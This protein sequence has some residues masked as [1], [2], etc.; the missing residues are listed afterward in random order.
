MFSRVFKNF[1]TIKYP[2]KNSDTRQM[3]SNMINCVEYLS[4]SKKTR[5]FD[6]MNNTMMIMDRLPDT[7]KLESLHDIHDLIL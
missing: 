7:L 1:F 5:V 3:Y 2:R 4:K 6:V